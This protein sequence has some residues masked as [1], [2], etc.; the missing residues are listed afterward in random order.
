MG[1]VRSG[2]AR[3]TLSCAS[4]NRGAERRG[5]GGI[6]PPVMVPELRL[7]LTDGLHSRCTATHH[8]YSARGAVSVELP[9]P[10]PTTTSTKKKKKGM[11]VIVGGD[12][13]GTILSVVSKDKKDVK[14]QAGTSR[15]SRR[16]LPAFK[17]PDREAEPRR[18]R[19]HRRDVSSSC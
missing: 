12:A 13:R 11:R 19:L 15:F 14:G 4:T 6:A 7:T 5:D 17:G 16:G 3:R 2:T 8:A 18:M 9:P 10:K 1:H